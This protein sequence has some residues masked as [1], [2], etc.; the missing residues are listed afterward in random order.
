MRVFTV[1]RYYI[2]NGKPVVEILG[3][4]SKRDKA[5][6]LFDRTPGK[7]GVELE[8]IERVLDDHERPPV[9]L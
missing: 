1:L 8:I 3:Q 4:F 9:D 5:D 7:P 6:A 2:E